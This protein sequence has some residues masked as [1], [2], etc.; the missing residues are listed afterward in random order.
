MGAGLTLRVDSVPAV[1][2][3][4]GGSARVVLPIAVGATPGVAKIRIV[5]KGGPWTDDVTREVRIVPSG[6]PVSVPLGGVLERLV[7]HEVS[8]P[9]GV[10]EGSVTTE[11]AVYPTPLASLT[12]AVAALLREPGGCFEQTSS[13]NYPNVMA[14][15][16]MKSHSGVDPALVKRAAEL[17]ESR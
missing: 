8:I 14:L 10:V 15:Q 16:Y 7:E 5:A 2:V 12:E 3:P 11:G 9:Q 4:P 1:D 17:H 13:S 6:F